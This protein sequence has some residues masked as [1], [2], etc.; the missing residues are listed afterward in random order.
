MKIFVDCS[1]SNDSGFVCVDE[2]GNYVTDLAG[3][4]CGGITHP[5]SVDAAAVWISEHPGLSQRLLNSVRT[6]IQDADAKVAVDD[7]TVEESVS[8]VAEGAV[9]PEV[10]PV[11][12]S[13][14]ESKEVAAEEPEQEEDTIEEPLAN[15]PAQELEGPVVEQSEGDEES[16]LAAGIPLQF[17]DELLAA[18]LDTVEKVIDHPD[19]SEVK[20]IGVK[21]RDKILAAIAGS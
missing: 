1:L 4:S 17:V 3:K 5:D 11:E 6:A 8:E 10:V 13:V 14:T 16:L 15:G 12:E 9:E 19:L 2:S 18:G 20:G 7:E 21:S